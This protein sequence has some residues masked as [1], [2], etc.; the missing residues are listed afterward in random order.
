V[1]L[2]ER[3]EPQV[4]QPQLVPLVLLVLVDTH[5]QSRR[6]Y[7]KGMGVHT[8]QKVEILT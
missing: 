8:L 6:P 5:V 1:V 2:V 3:L 7:R 4:P